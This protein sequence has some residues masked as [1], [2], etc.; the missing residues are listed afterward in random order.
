MMR[1]KVRDSQ[2]RRDIMTLTQQIWLAQ[3]CQLFRS[4]SCSPSII[5]RRSYGTGRPAI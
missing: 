5:G 2:R 3:P 4:G 1:I